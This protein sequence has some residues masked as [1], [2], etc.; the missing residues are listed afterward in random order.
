M[1]ESLQS[2]NQHLTHISVISGL[3]FEEDKPASR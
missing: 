1:T 3:L 2:S